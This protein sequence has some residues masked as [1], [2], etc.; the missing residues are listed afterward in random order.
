[1]AVYVGLPEIGG[2]ILVCAHD[3]YHWITSIPPQRLRVIEHD[4]DHRRHPSRSQQKLNRRLSRSSST[5]CATPRG[6]RG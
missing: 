3:L 2:G 5:A 4:R 1:M 6:L